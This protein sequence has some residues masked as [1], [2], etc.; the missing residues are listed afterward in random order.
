[1]GT[2]GGLLIP[3]VVVSVDF[4][5]ADFCIVLDLDLSL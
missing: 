3:A 2:E 5:E 4:E 1:M